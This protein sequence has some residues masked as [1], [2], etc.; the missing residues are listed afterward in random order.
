MLKVNE[1]N[2]FEEIH[3]VSLTLPQ[4]FQ[5]YQAPRP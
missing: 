1:T 2:N 5:I 3:P 4:S